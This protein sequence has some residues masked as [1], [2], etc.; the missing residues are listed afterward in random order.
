[1]TEGKLTGTRNIPKLKPDERVAMRHRLKMELDARRWLVSIG[2]HGAC[3]C[4]NQLALSRVGIA[5]KQHLQH[6]IRVAE[7]LCNRPVGCQD[8]SLRALGSMAN[9]GTVRQGRCDGTRTRT[10]GRR[11]R[12]QRSRKAHTL[13]C[14]LSSTISQTLKALKSRGTWECCARASWTSPAFGLMGM[15]AG[16]Q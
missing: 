7:L 3:N 2:E 14:K 10:P 13:Q 9:R 16:V 15:V 12:A 1:M 5:D 6:V 8:Q 4:V 11:T